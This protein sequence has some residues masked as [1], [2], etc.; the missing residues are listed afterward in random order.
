MSRLHAGIVALAALSMLGVIAALSIIAVSVDLVLPDTFGFR[1]FPVIFAVV[2]TWVGAALTW[3]TPNN[4]IGWLLLGIGVVAGVQAGLTEYSAFAVIGRAM[5]L[6]GGVIAGWLV[7]WIWVT[8]PTAVVVFL[9]LLF[10]DGHLLSPRW[11]AFAFLGGGSALAAMFALAFNAGPLQDAPYADNPFPLFDDPGFV[12]F[13]ACMLGLAVAGFGAAAS[14]VVR[15]RRSGGI[16]RQQ[17]KWLSFEGL[18]LAVAVVTGSFSI[19]QKLGQILL[20]AAVSLAPVMVA[21]AVLRYRLYDIDVLIN[22]ALVYGATSAAIGGSFFVGIV[23]LTSVLRPLTGG[24]EIAV[25]VSTLAGFALFQPVRRRMQ[26]GVD[27]RFYRSRYDAARTLDEFTGRLAGEVD[28]GA[29]R[30][31]LLAAVGDTLQPSSA[32]VWLRNDSRTLGG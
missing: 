18:V 31:S 14:L 24:S 20:I 30:A 22:R 6:T 32:S 28:L 9:L 2:F 27:R 15:Y 10:P 7:S 23:I 4:A 5:P 12:A 8:E 11:R 19:G 26:R 21:I 3:R 29:V 25:A 17:L 13:T 16:E 1:G